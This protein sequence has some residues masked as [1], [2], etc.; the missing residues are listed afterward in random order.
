MGEYLE[1]RLDFGKQRMRVE[2]QDDTVVIKDVA[3]TSHIDNGIYFWTLSWTGEMIF[4][5]EDVQ[6]D[7]D[8]SH[9]LNSSVRDHQTEIIITRTWN[10]PL[11]VWMTGFR[12]PDR[13]KD[14]STDYCTHRIFI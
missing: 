10:M 8:I 3:Q 14:G 2:F 1:Q 11:D 9:C 7:S 6:N 4:I 5:S 12:F 13:I